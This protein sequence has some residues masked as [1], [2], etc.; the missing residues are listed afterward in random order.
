[1]IIYLLVC[2]FMPVLVQSSCTD[3]KSWLDESFAGLMAKPKSGIIHESGAKIARDAWSLASQFF[4][5]Q[6]KAA[7]LYDASNQK[8]LQKCEMRLEKKMKRKQGSELAC[9]KDLRDDIRTIRLTDQQRIAQWEFLPNLLTNCATASDAMAAIHQQVAPVRASYRADGAYSAGTSV[10]ATPFGPQALSPVPGSPP[11]EPVGLTS[12]IQVCGAH[13]VVIDGP[14]VID[15]DAACDPARKKSVFASIKQWC[16]DNPKKAI[17]GTVVSALVLGLVIDAVKRKGRS[18]LGR[19]GKLVS[20]FWQWLT[21]ADANTRS[22]QE[23]L[24]R[25][26]CVRLAK[27]ILEAETKLHSEDEVAPR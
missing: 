15:A 7:F 22:K 2:F 5:C 13:G 8:R 9:L 26:D 12:A 17:T 10:T 4:A 18:V 6:D 27:K 24:S 14:V 3:K 25:E 11:N 20:R 16:C 19:G 1:M 21:T 23:I